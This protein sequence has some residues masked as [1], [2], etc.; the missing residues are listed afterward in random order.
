MAKGEG[1]LTGSISWQMQHTNLQAKKWWHKLL[2][3]TLWLPH[4]KPSLLRFDLFGGI[5]L[6]SYVLP[7][8]MAYAV[9]AG[10]HP[11]AGIYC[12]L[13]GGVIVAFFTTSKQVA[14]GPTSAIS[15][16]V[17][18][19]LGALAQGDVAKWAAMSAFAALGVGLISMAAYT[20]RL[21]TLVNF[22]SETV[23]LGFKTG[24]AITIGITVVPDLLGIN[25]AAM[26]FSRGLDTFSTILGRQTQRFI[27]SALL[28]SHY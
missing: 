28:P 27:F 24:A 17:G 16:L 18:T 7:A 3:I 4:Y 12:Y 8:S 21:N 25:G 20:V 26:I 9:L 23:L 19:T 2:P 11:Q 6:A 13:V 14:L 22:I 15:L 1:G 5:A 10:L